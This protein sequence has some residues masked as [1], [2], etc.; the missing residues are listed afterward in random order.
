MPQQPLLVSD[1][2][3]IPQG[4]K[5]VKNFSV[6]T[7]L[8]ASPGTVLG[9]AVIS[10]ATVS[11]AAANTSLTWAA[12]VVTV[13]T[14]A[15]HGIPVGQSV[16][17]TIAGVT[18]AG[19]NGTFLATSTGANTFTYSLASNPGTETVPGTWVLVPVGSINDSTTTAAAALGN[20]VGV[21]P[22][23]AGDVSLAP[24]VPCNSG[25]TVS[26]PAGNVTNG[27]VAV[28]YV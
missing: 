21:L 28:W 5:S 24:G 8:K 12:S 6:P 23:T 19:Y 26:P 10:A 14:T 2:N 20:Q 27:T 11:A 3:L 4:A 25:I 22:N 17:V 18:P 15:A 7:V 1:A 16:F 13:T 9:F